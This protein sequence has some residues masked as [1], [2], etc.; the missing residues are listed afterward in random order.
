MEQELLLAKYAEYARA[1]GRLPTR[2]DLH[3]KRQT[4]ASFPSPGTFQNRLG[5]KVEL[6]EKL[7][8]YCQKHSGFAEVIVLCEAYLRAPGPDGPA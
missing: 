7:L 6:V 8:A 3:Q 1:L 5:P 2:R 4:D